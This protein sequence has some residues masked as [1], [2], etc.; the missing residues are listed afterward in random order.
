MAATDA[1]GER[2]HENL[3][4]GYPI[5]VGSLYSSAT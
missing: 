4:F 5:N 3:V 1:K 2:D